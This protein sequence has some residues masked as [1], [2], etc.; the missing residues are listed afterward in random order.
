MTNDETELRL[1]G[2][3]PFRH[4]SLVIRIFLLFTLA[5]CTAQPSTH[6]DDANIRAF[7]SRYFSTWSA[8]DMDG[9]AACFHPQ[10]RVMFIGESGQILSQ[11]LTDFLHSQRLAHETASVPMTEK[12]VEM[13]LQGDAKAVQA[14]VTW[15]LTKGTTEERGTDFFTLKREGNDWKIVCLVFYGE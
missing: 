12:P 6:P 3:K 9:Y 14:Q 8:K 5:S 2:S 11:G 1:R 15:V 4:S 7:L 13:T 10:A